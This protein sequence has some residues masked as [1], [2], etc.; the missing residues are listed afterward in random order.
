MSIYLKTSEKETPIDP[1]KIS[2]DIFLNLYKRAVRKFALNF[3][4]T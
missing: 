2:E 1:D 4:L 3:R